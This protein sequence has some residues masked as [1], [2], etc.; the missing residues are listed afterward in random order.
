M[1]S[2]MI[3][4]KQQD[5]DKWLTIKKKS[6]FIH[7]ALNQPNGLEGLADIIDDSTDVGTYASLEPATEP[8]RFPG[9]KPHI[10][11]LKKGKK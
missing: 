7:N 5:Y 11:Y 3:Y 9:D 6:E 4:I 1:P 10:N 2:V 8:P